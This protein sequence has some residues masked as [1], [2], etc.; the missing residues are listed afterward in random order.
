MSMS[1]KSYAVIECKKGVKNWAT[2]KS[3]PFAVC[4]THNYIAVDNNMELRGSLEFC[5]L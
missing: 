4:N 5:Y 1:V 2:E 3:A